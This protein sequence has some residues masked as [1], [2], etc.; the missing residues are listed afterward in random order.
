MPMLRSTKRH[1]IAPRTITLDLETLDLNFGPW[2]LDF[3]T[4]VLVHSE[5]DVVGTLRQ[6][7]IVFI[8]GVNPP[9]IGAFF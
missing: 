5:L 7:P 6:F 4:L 3:W 9:S 2:T 8:E 1:T